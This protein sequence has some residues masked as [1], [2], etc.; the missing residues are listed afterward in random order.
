MELYGTYLPTD[1][2]AIWRTILQLFNLKFARKDKV[3]S[4]S[5]LHATLTLEGLTNGR[6]RQ[7]G[8]GSGTE[9]PRHHALRL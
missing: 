8:A 9:Q 2:T 5:D 3:I 4:F 7:E 6:W 1:Y